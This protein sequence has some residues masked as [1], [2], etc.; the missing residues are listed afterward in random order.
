MRRKNQTAEAV[1]CQQG[2]SVCP[3]VLRGPG[4]HTPASVAPDLT[5]LHRGW[6]RGL[7]LRP[8]LLLLL[9]QRSRG[10]GNGKHVCK[11][12]EAHPIFQFHPPTPCPSSPHT[13]PGMQLNSSPLPAVFFSILG[14]HS[15]VS[16]V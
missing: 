6:P 2:V 7:E 15:S 13:A 11:S 4:F 9:L 12:F 3:C 14:L 8:A 5:R 1:T 16:S 10:G